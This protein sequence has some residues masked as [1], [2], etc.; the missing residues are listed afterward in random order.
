MQA[1]HAGFA[2]INTMILAQQTQNAILS[3][4]S[5][6]RFPST[7]VNLCFQFATDRRRNSVRQPHITQQTIVSLLVQN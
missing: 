4:G 7:V 1:H 6:N 3:T 2:C 5:L